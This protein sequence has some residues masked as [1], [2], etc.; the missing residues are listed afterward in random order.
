MS[1]RNL[2]P[3]QFGVP[4]NGWGQSQKY[5]EGKDGRQYRLQEGVWREITAHTIGPKNDPN[6]KPTPQSRIGMLTYFGGKP[7][8]DGS[9]VDGGVIHKVSVRPRHQRNG[10]ATAMLDFARERNPDKDVRHSNVLS[11]DGAAW[12]AATPTPN[13]LKPFRKEDS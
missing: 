8:Y 3:E 11:E 10:V 5:I 2:N 1:Y 9:N 13:D 4:D 7:T 12:A 6:K